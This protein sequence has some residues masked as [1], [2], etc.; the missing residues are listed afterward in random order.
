MKIN[1]ILICLSLFTTINAFAASGSGYHIVYEKLI[2]SH[3]VKGGMI[4]LD[5]KKTLDDHPQSIYAIA[6]DLYN[7]VRLTSNH[8]VNFYNSSSQKVRF[9]FKY[10]VQCEEASE[11]YDSAVDLDPNG[12]FKD[13]TD[14][15]VYVKK[16]KGEYPIV[17][18]TVASGGFNQVAESDATLH[19][20]K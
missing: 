7:D 3:G 8:G 4:K 6:H 13:D 10:S 14:L 18:K 15:F 12:S 19:I 17:A 2:T 11:E 5:Q 9:Y 20:N 16:E 1:K